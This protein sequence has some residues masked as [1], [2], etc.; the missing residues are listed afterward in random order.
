MA[1]KFSEYRKAIRSGYR[2]GFRSGWKA[3][4]NYP[5]GFG[6]RTAVKIGFG[7][8]MRA[9]KRSDRDIKRSEE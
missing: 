9:H 7:K 8:G 5:K 4:E 1:K 3:H 2:Y 6:V